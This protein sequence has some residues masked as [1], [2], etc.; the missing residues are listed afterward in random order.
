[1]KKWAYGNRV[2]QYGWRSEKLRSILQRMVERVQTRLGLFLKNLETCEVEFA[3]VL[4][5]RYPARPTTYHEF[6]ASNRHVASGVLEL[7][8]LV[9]GVR[10]VPY[11]FLLR[12]APAR[13]LCIH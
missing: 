12:L 1:M 13:I 9:D 11:V 3:E 7:L 6:V 4:S 8:V 10:P 2:L 5:S